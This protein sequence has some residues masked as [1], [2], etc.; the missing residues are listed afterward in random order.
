M[1]QNSSNALRQLAAEANMHWLRR[2]L[3][4]RSSNLPYTISRCGKYMFIFLFS[5]AYYQAQ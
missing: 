5:L 4:T 1:G 2:Q 3:A